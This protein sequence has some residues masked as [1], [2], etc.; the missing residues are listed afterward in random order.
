M[1]VSKTD[2]NIVKLRFKFVRQFSTNAVFPVE[3]ETV[4]SL[5]TASKPIPPEAVKLFNESHQLWLSTVPIV[6]SQIYVYGT[7]SLPRPLELEMMRLTLRQEEI[8]HELTPLVQGT[9]DEAARRELVN[10]S[11]EMMRIDPNNE[12]EKWEYDQKEAQAAR[13]KEERLMVEAGAADFIKQQANKLTFNEWREATLFHPSAGSNCCIN[14]DSGAV[15]TPPPEILKAMTVTNH[16]DEGNF[17][18]E[19]HF[20]AAYRAESKE[21]NLLAN[22]I[23]KSNV[24]AV[25]LGTDGLVVFCPVHVEGRDVMDTGDG[26]EKRISPAWL[27]WKLYYEGKMY[28]AERPLPTNT[29]EVLTFTPENHRTSQDLCLFRTRSRTLGILQITGFTKNPPGVKIRYKLVQT[30]KN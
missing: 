11:W 14:F 22:W 10:L 20:W 23:E 3:S 1:Q 26:W 12:R 25:P 15:L 8:K 21:T 19:S 29:Y 28:A 18:T 27:L 13:F 17:W 6:S 4:T 24:D 2:E 9:A 30:G 16:P 5:V 7:N